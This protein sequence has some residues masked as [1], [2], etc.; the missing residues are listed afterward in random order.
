M[1]AFVILDGYAANFVQHEN[2]DLIICSKDVSKT[3]LGHEKLVELS[4]V[5]QGKELEQF[6][7][8][9]REN[10]FRQF[11]EKIFVLS[12]INDIFKFIM[13]D[14]FEIIRVLRKHKVTEVFL[15]EGHKSIHFLSVFLAANTEVSKPLFSTRSRI[16][17]PLIFEWLKQETII[18]VNWKMESRVKLRCIQFIRNCILFVASS[19]TILSVVGN[20]KPIN[21]KHIAIY[22]TRDQLINLSALNL[23]IENIDFVQGPNGTKIPQSNGS[24]FVTIKDFIYSLLVSSKRKIGLCFK[25][26]SKALQL[27]L[28]DVR[29]SIP[30]REIEREA[31]SIISSSAYEFALARLAKNNPEC[32]FFSSEMSSR[33]AVIEKKALSNE[34][35]FTGKVVGVQFV[36]LGTIKVPFFPV[37]D[38]LV[39]K[40]SSEHKSLQNFYDETALKYFGSL[41]LLTLIEKQEQI[42]EENVVGFFTQPYGQE[43]N[44]R[45]IQTIERCLPPNW[46]LVLRVHPRDSADYRAGQLTELDQSPHFSDLLVRSKIVVAKSSSVLV[47]ANELGK[48][49]ISVCFDEY[50]R[51]VANS[52]VDSTQ[53]V[54]SVA[55]FKAQIEVFLSDSSP[56]IQA[57]YNRKE[58]CFNKTLFLESL[59][60]DC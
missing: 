39:S 7:T 28:F 59:K 3:F 16:L 14:L 31:I 38:L 8:Q 36:T 21:R 33:F 15:Y 10:F 25:R 6:S 11:E 55:A 52:L 9:F 2:Q 27:N 51:Q 12:Q 35:S 24:S 19:Y 49:V 32:V 13:T 5:V 53:M 34:P 60:H 56:D 41:S 58:L 23:I 1:K 45:I 44:F 22:R 4:G 47:D 37:Q 42:S 17:N 54:Y 20:S 57:S 29:I 43:D 40:S 26:K 30:E 50:S 48:K 46:K 18:K